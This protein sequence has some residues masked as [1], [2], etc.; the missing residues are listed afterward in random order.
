MYEAIMAEEKEIF[1]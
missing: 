1:I